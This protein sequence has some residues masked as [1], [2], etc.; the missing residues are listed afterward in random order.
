MTNNTCTERCVGSRYWGTKCWKFFLG[1]CRFSSSSLM[2]CWRYS[3]L[4]IFGVKQQ[5]YTEAN[6]RDLADNGKFEA[7][8][9]YNFE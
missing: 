9:L 8:T 3:R 4:D 7:G 5:C 6:A 2:G 1:G